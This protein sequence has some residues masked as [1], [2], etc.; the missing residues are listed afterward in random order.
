MVMFHVMLS[1]SAPILEPMYVLLSD[2]GIG[3]PWE[4]ALARVRVRY[5]DIARAEA[6]PFS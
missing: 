5:R 4:R 3:S 6:I 2:F 1:I